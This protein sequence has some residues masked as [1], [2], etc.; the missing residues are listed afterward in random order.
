MLVNSLD[1]LL[2]GRG[3]EVLQGFWG[4]FRVLRE[5]D[6]LRIKKGVSAIRL[7]D[8]P[9]FPYFFM[10]SGVMTLFAALSSG[11]YRRVHLFRCVFPDVRGP[12]SI[13]ASR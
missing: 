9:G 1:V 4:N 12:A 2:S 6:P 5:F 11:L 7:A 8:T 10:L 13:L 3:T